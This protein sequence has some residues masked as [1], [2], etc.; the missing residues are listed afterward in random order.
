MLFR[1]GKETIRVFE[2]EH[3][4]LQ[5][6][7]PCQQPHRL[8]EGQLAGFHCL[9]VT[10]EQRQSELVA[11]R[12]NDQSLVKIFRPVQVEHQVSAYGRPLRKMSFHEFEER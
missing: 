5:R 12:V 9:N 11:K 1:F 8:P 4:A 3:G 10:D 2:A 7:F 6:G